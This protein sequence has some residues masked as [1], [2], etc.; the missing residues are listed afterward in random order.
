MH[1]TSITYDVEMYPEIRN[2]A[3]T[4][5]LVAANVTLSFFQASFGNS[6]LHPTH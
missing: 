3:S 6:Y 4:I 1:L 2:I 5:D